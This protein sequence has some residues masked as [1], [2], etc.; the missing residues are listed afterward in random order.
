MK[1]ILFTISIIF[2]INSW[3]TAPTLDQLDLDQKVQLIEL[4]N[5]MD[6]QVLESLLSEEALSW[7]IDQFQRTE[8]APQ[9]A[10]E[11]VLFE[12]I[13]SGFENGIGHFKDPFA[14]KHK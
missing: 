5:Q 7:Y 1:F 8:V 14:P 9:N 10:E 3:A 11:Q 4:L 13:Q 12:V 2:S 6:H